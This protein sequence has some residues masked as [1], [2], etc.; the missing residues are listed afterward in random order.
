MIICFEAIQSQ[1]GG[2]GYFFSPGREILG[3]SG[4]KRIQI[5]IWHAAAL[6]GTAVV[7]QDFLEVS[8]RSR[9]A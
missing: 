9:P 8:L 3:A 4:G 2:D 1:M 5:S 6:A 7:E